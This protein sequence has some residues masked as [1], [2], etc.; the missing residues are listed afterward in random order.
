MEIQTVKKM[1][2]HQLPIEVA[3]MIEH[4]SECLQSWEQLCP[5][6]KHSEF[7]NEWKDTLK[8]HIESAYDASDDPDA[9]L[10]DSIT[11]GILE[12][13]SAWESDAF[14]SDI[15]HD[16][17]HALMLR[18]QTAQRTSDWYTE[19]KLRLTAS[20]ISKVFGSPRER[21]T[22]VMMKAG[23]LEVPGRGGPSVCRRLTMSP[24]DWG[25]CFEP[26]VKQIVEF[27]WDAMIHECGRFVHLTDTR[28]AASPDG[29]ILRSKKHPDMAG[30]LIEIK[31]PKSRKIGLKIPSDYY[32][33]MQLQLEV[34]GMRACEYVEAR[35]DFTNSDSDSDSFPKEKYHGKVAVVGCFKEEFQEWLPCRYEYGPINQLDWTPVLGLNEQTL[36][37][38]T[39]VCDAFHHERVH[40]DE[41][42]FATRLPKLE[43]FWLDVEKAKVGDFTLPES[44][45][46][47]KDVACLIVD[48]PQETPQET[49]PEE[50]HANEPPVCLISED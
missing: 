47:K 37:L 45:R 41:A 50:T 21:G 5:K 8:S 24:F 2:K 38:N 7:V 1:N 20:E 26:V 39:W 36:E 40:R 27:H 11:E 15:N 33:Q 16:L 6:P 14:P 13:Y 22:L 44:S 30:H 49:S 9:E 17:I 35:I 43:E 34:T 48:E 42:W 31:C 19:F 23:K 18:P 25:I 46:K 12:A 4:L 32:Y 28:L 10:V 29:L 3:R